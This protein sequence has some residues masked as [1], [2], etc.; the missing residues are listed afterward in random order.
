[1]P[2]WTLECLSA[3]F[4][5]A[6]HGLRIRLTSWVISPA[7]LVQQMPYFFPTTAK[8]LPCS[9]ALLLQSPHLGQEDWSDRSIPVIRAT[10]LTYFFRVLAQVSDSQMP[11]R[12]YLVDP[13]HGLDGRLMSPTPVR[14]LVG[15]VGQLDIC[16]VL[17][18]KRSAALASHWY[19][20]PA[21]AR[22]RCFPERL[23]TLPAEVRT[24]PTASFTELTIWCR[25]RF[26]LFIAS[27]RRPI[28]SLL[29]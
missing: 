6:C 17:S 4:K 7:G 24:M 15:P 22:R 26:I 25:S 18:L 19:C 8:P 11:R 23:W 13:L 1:M 29:R 28:S 9:P 2:S 21:P 12:D 3:R 20:W 10:H 16:C 14:K 27:V 5:E